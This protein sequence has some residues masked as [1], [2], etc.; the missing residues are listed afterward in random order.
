MQSHDDGSAGPMGH[1]M[2]QLAKLVGAFVIE[3]SLMYSLQHQ[4]AI[5]GTES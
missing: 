2:L 1:Q 3:S 4:A 5:P